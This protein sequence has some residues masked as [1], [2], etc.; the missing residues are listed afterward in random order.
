MNLNTLFFDLDATLYP[1]SNGLWQAIRERIDL[2]MRKIMGF[3]PEEIPDIRQRLF[4]NHG[5]TLR[6]LQIHYDID[7]ANYLDFVHD[8]PLKEFISPDPALRA[9]LMSIPYRCWIFTNSDASHANRVMNILGITDCFEGM[10]DVWTMDPL[11]KPQ[12]DAYT[13]AL[14]Y[15]G[16]N[17]SNTCAFLDDSPRNLATAKKL[18]FF[19]VLVGQNGTNPAAHRSLVDIHD[20]PKVVP[21]FWESTKD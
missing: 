12:E 15:V 1:E 2:Y 11:C 18:G 10:I 7:P 9:M 3:A 19:T 6:G 21:E 8:L 16:V 5:T 13:F 14:D 17:D 4:I 20:L